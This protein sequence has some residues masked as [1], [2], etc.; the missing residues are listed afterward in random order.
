M[1]EADRALLDH[2]EGSFETIGAL[3]DACKLRAA[4][5]ETM[6]VAREVNRYLDEQAPW[7]QIKQDRAA[8]ARSVYVALRAIDSLKTLT[9]PFLPFSSQKLHETAGLRGQHRWPAVRRH[10]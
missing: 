10:V 9:N 7:F 5:T 6:A 3:I 2:V 4:L 8:A 1:D